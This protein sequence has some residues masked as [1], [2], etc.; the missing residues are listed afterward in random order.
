[1]MFRQQ[2]DQ[3]V[4]DLNKTHP[5]YIRCIKPNANKAAHDFDSL[6]V[7]RQLRC[8][9]MLESIRIRRAGYPVRKPFKEFF[10]RFRVLC[11]NITTAGRIDPDYKELVKRFL[12]E[13]ESKL[14]AK[15]CPIPDRAFQI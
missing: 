7:Q 5:R 13:M 12:T 4:E 10:N 9:G 11:P 6:D 2:L 1:M 14:K 8:A 15:G 3:L